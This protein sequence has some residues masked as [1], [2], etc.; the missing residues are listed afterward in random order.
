MTSMITVVAFIPILIICLFIATH[1]S[2]SFLVYRDAKTLE[3]SA[4]GISP[5]LWFGIAFSLPILGMFIYWLMNYST[6]SKRPL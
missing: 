1:I 3:R 6:L 4:L 5:F 2:I